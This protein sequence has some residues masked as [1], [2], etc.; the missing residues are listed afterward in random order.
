MQN[1]KEIARL[2]HL[3]LS[4]RNIAKQCRVS[5]NTV[6]SLFKNLDSKGLD[7]LSLKDLDDLQIQA[8]LNQSKLSQ[9]ET[10]YV[11]PDYSR[12][13]DEL[14]KPGVTMQLL[15]EEYAQNCRRS[16][17]L[18][19]Q[20]TQFKKHFNDYLNTHRFTDVIHHKPGERVEVDWAGTPISYLDPDHG[21]VVQ[22][23]LFVGVLPFSGY[24]FAWACSDQRQANWNN[25]HAQMF[26]Y[27]K[28]VPRLL[29]PDNLKTGVI[30]RPKFEDPILND[31]YRELAQHYGCVILPTRVRK[32]KDK[33]SVENGV[34]QLTRMI[35]ARLRNYQ[36]F[37]LEEYNH[38]LRIE[39]DAYNHKPFQ[40]K[41]GSRFEIFH[42]HEKQTL[43]A[44]PA[45]AYEFCQWRKA[46]VQSNSHVAFDKR[47]YS[48]PYT[49]IGQE[50]DIKIFKQTIEIYLRGV[51]IARHAV[52]HRETG[53]Y[54]TD[55]QHMPANSQ[56]H[57]NWSKARFLNEA[58][59]IGPSTHRII[60]QLF[61]R[62]KAEEQGYSSAKA[63]LKLSEIYSS[64]RL[65]KACLVLLTQGLYPRYKHIK[66]VLQNGQD[67]NTNEDCEI[68]Q[69]Q[70]KS[71]VRGGQY[72]AR[73]P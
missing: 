25:A 16:E 9:R 7:Y 3:G 26:E 48:V 69:V 60:E 46:K 8:V 63:I 39:L 38:Q 19:Y 65:E 57:Q 15:W 58:K 20:I 54:I 70:E 56:V 23:S 43:S 22:A 11:L 13:A 61:D 35:L 55:A 62:V 21:G 32:P 6:H 33:A 1:V 2:R 27:F 59:D 50:V 53:S 36:F 29:I 51:L 18:Y 44:L 30:R 31:S 17:C 34:G 52:T 45:Y 72:Y 5:R 68:E 40:K 24:A 28:G 66:T 73:K 41:P 37:T 4:Q 14:V 64:Q 42:T 47:Y 49:T 12:L 71:F 67:K 10:Q